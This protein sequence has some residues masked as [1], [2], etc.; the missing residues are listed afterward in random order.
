M[1]NGNTSILVAHGLRAEPEVVTLTLQNNQAG[2]RGLDQREERQ[3]LHHRHQCGGG[4]RRAYLLGGEGRGDD[5]VGN[6]SGIPRSEEHTSELQSLMRI[7]Y[8]VFCL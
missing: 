7:S 4:R 8:A 2:G 1:L 5:L 3:Q 6:S